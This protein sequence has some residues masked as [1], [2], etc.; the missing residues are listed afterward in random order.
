MGLERG[1]DVGP[2]INAKQ[3]ERVTELVDLSTRNGAE[4]L[5]GGK[6]RGGKGYFFEP[7][8]VTGAKPGVPV[9]DEEIFGP[10]MPVVKFSDREEVLQLANDTEYGLAA[11]VLT[12]DL[13][14]SIRMSEGL[15]YG[16]VCINDWL[17]AT[18]EAPFGGVKGSGFGRETG[19][20]GIFEYME[21]KSIFTGGV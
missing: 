15:Q 19:S 4:V 7:T 11:F 10:V 2:L 16:M 8:V 9:Y 17:P 18:P 20:E 21:T 1:T 14:T 12:N 3:R 5:T 13:N 6:P